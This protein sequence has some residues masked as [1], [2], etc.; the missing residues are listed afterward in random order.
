M[1]ENFLRHGLD[2]GAGRLDIG[3]PVRED[4]A[5]RQ[6]RRT[7]RLALNGPGGASRFWYQARVVASARGLRLDAGNLRA[8]LGGFESAVGI[9]IGTY[10]GA[11]V[12]FKVS[13]GANKRPR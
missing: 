12:A 1:V 8:S 5:C 7:R 10:D 3:A 9:R 4:T 2:C 13:K 11:R 6:A